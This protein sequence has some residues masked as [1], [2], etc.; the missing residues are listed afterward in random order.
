MF[1][2][3]IVG[4]FL[5][6]FLFYSC[7]NLLGEDEVDTTPP[8]SV[9]SVITIPIDGGV[10]L[11]WTDPSNSDLATISIAYSSTTESVDAG[12][13]FIEITGLSNGSTITFSLVAVDDS[14]NSSSTVTADVTPNID[15]TPPTDVDLLEVEDGDEE[16]VLTWSDPTED[17][18]YAVEISYDSTTVVIDAGVESATITGLTNGN[19]YNFTVKTVD[20]SENSSTGVEIT[21]EPVEPPVVD[22]IDTGTGYA[23]NYVPTGSEMTRDFDSVSWNVVNCDTVSEIHA[24][25]N[26]ASPGDK[27]VISAGTYTGSDDDSGSSKAYFY[28][29]ASGTKDNPI[30][31]VNES[32]SEVVL[33]GDDN[34]SDYVLYITGDYIAVE[35][36]TFKTGNQG[37]IL[38]NS[39]Y[40]LIDSVEVY[41]IG[42]EAIHVRDG[43]SYTIIKDSNIHDTGLKNVKYGEGVYVG[44]DNGKWTDNGGSYIKECDYVQILNNTIG[45]NVT[46]E[47]IDIK[48]GSSYT[49]I[50]GNTFDAEGMTDILNGGLS[51]IDFK[52]NNAECGYNEGD[53]NGNQYFENAFE[54]NDKW[55]GWGDNNYIHNNTVTFNDDYYFPSSTSVTLT[56]PVDGVTGSQ[57]DTIDRD[58]WV[59]ECNDQSSA[60][61]QP[62]GTTVFN[63]T[64]IPEN[65]DRMYN[66]SSRITEEEL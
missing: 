38:D 30:W 46:A 66:S 44:S 53:Q 22:G 33:Q 17:D 2:R 54:V 59:V 31:V 63:N 43:S 20:Y 29:S 15:N 11:K 18:F 9:S 16:V 42:Q 56:I 13:E 5:V 12:V 14:G 6:V 51:F 55:P 52:G 19:T 60:E 57:T 64:R 41:D 45:P 62:D 1:K 36:I 47:H 28:I 3:L 23:E 34:T 65:S 27:I 37:I 21:G 24:A 48:E 25:F 39:N 7:D 4:L 58:Q 50:F 40:S 10:I 8:D 61:G 35:N 32:D 49:Y 26:S